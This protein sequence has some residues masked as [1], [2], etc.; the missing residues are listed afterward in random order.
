MSA[1]SFGPTA[2][3]EK[4]LR[5]IE[6]CMD[7]IPDAVLLDTAYNSMLRQ[8][9]FTAWRTLDV[10]RRYFD[11]LAEV[12]SYYFTP[13]PYHLP[14]LRF[15]HRQE[16]VAKSRAALA[17]LLVTPSPSQLELKWKRRELKRLN[18]HVPVDPDEVEA[19]IHADE[20][21]LAAHPTRRTSKGGRKRGGGANG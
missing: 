3:S 10:E 20:I 19:S 4:L 15:A 7:P 18:S 16:Y 2:S 5:F 14:G 8:Q 17:K 9:R 11:A 1:N 12:A 13:K 6:A 21:F